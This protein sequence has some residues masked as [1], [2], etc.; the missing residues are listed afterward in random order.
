MY[1]H[2]LVIRVGAKTKLPHGC[3][4]FPIPSPTHFPHSRVHEAPSTGTGTA[5]CVP[6]VRRPTR[7]PCTFDN[8]GGHT[9]NREAGGHGGGRHG[10][11]SG[12]ESMDVR[13]VRPSD[14]GRAEAVPRHGERPGPH[15]DRR[16]RGRGRA[17]YAAVQVDSGT[18]S[19]LIG[20]QPGYA[21][22]ALK[23]AKA[24]AQQAPCK[25][26]ITWPTVI[27]SSAASP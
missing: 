26:T 20:W 15:D 14:D 11:R 6:P 7:P 4:T 17:P 27:P 9:N 16:G 5:T 3:D 2:V 23:I 10:A 8:I 19:S 24:V 12:A 22:I 13:Q 25:N 18:T 21:N 1:S